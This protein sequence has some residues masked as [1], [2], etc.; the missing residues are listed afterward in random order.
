MTS[1]DPPTTVGV[2]LPV[3]I[4]TRF[5]DSRLRVLIVPDEPW[6]DRHD[7]LPGPAELDLLERYVA[8][9]GDN[10]GAPSARQAWRTFASQVGGGR[11]TWLVRTFRRIASDR[12]IRVERPAAQRD[13]ARLPELPFF[14]PE[15]QVW[16]ARDGAPPALALTLHVDVSR[17]RADFPD[18]DDATDRRWWE[19]WDEAVLTGVA[20]EIDLGGSP[21][22]IEA[23]Y[24][25]GLG[26]DEQE[27][28]R[29]FAAHEAAGR[30]GLIAPGTPTNTVDAAPAADLGDD[31]DTWLTGL[32]APV[33]P[34]SA[35]VSAAL[36]GA[37]G[38]HIPLNNDHRHRDHTTALVAGLWPALWGFAQ[39]NVWGIPHAEQAPA[40]AAEALYPEGPYP[41]LRIGTQP[42]GLLPVTALAAWQA[43]PADP[44]VESAMVPA[45][46]LLR[47][48]WA[49]AAESRGTIE[50]ADTNGLLDHLAQVPTSPGYRHRD[51]RPLEVWLMSLLFLDYRI[52]WRHVVDAWRARTPLAVALD[53]TP[54]R[55][56]AAVGGS[57]PLRLPLVVPAG[58][59]TE[60]IATMLRRL[61]QAA[62]ATPGVLADPE[63]L[64]ADVLGAQPD[65][66]LL[67]LAIRALQ[68]AVG[69]V[70]RAKVA[71]FRWLDP[72][73]RRHTDRVPLEQ[74][75][76]AVAPGDLIAGT[77]A[78]RA[79]ART[80]GGLAAIAD[81]AGDER[82]LDRALSATVDC[83]TYRVDAWVTGPATRRLREL[84]DAP[85]NARGWRLGAYGWVDRPR[86][87]TPGP[88]AA[89]M[90]PA[91]SQSQ[92][93]VAMIL[94]DRAVN[95]AEAGRWHM[96]LSSTTVRTA[97]RLAAA[98]RA[99]THLSEVLGH[100][101]ERVVAEPIAVERLRRDY[102]VRAGHSGRRVCDG[103][104][105]LAAD[106]ATLDLP[107][108]TLTG[109]AQLAAAVDAYGDLLMAEAVQHVVE[110]RAETAGAVL[111]AV[112]GLGRPPDL[113]VIGT[114]RPGRAVL[115]VCV[116]LLPAA[117]PPALPT[118]PGPLSE[119]SPGTLADP[120]FAAFLGVQLGGGDTWTW[121][122]GTGTTV[123]LADLGL[124]P[125]DALAFTGA[126]LERLAADAAGAPL[127]TRVGSARHDRAVRLA[128]LLGQS[129]ATAQALA[130]D[131]APEVAPADDTAVRLRYRRVRTVAQALLARLRSDSPAD[132]QA[133]L[134]AARRW[135]IAP[136]EVTGETPAARAA[137]LLAARLA[138]APGGDLP[139]P[140]T[141]DLVPALVS[142]VS[143]TG[144][145]AVLG[146]LR[147]AEVPGLSPVPELDRDWLTVVAAVR[148]PLAR[149]EAHQLAAGGP[150]SAG[151]AFTSW[152]SRPADPWQTADPPSRLVAGYAAAG[153]DIAA[154]GADDE[155]A[156]A[157]LDRFG[158]TIPGTQ[159][160]PSVV[161]GFAAPT[162]RA[163]QAVLLAVPP[164]PARPLTTADLVAAVAEARLLA[165]ARIARPADLE[166]ARALLPT[167]LL[168]AEGT[169]AVPLVPTPFQES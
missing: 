75:I 105:V 128:L 87:G 161:F 72:I 97:D 27:P 123:T 47:D 100:E 140:V 70:G 25:V 77:P 118:E 12:T 41:T 130:D 39:C 49:A 93:T 19:S 157:L 50:S 99:G 59:T 64:H 131:S 48:E 57:A 151:P 98:V 54:R 146:R 11:A 78:A 58:M 16:L 125:I 155:V 51:A 162:A 15:L 37:D 85:A 7:P 86:T 137:E 90:L 106:P 71:D 68:V 165:H 159:H 65:S 116:A 45:L 127:A 14:P 147:G 8:V 126:H 22:D 26:G 44:P 89:G 129:P 107:A 102:P 92:A 9:A 17:L 150:A 82:R 18:P 80:A 84:H 103:Q 101:V 139:E 109:L 29:L 52:G 81:L 40:W 10:P 144:R 115:T 53:L 122:T 63:R 60:A 32:L 4:E 96:D 36:T 13:T 34:S 5:D 167:A 152:S 38:L 33:P 141:A 148:E 74:W 160:A 111:D 133:A 149:L 46:Q 120:S 135:G 1:I 28:A 143:P 156:V 23:L 110:G 31:P 20:G 168:P 112:A 30:L 113:S 6:F 3:R 66:L 134:A 2:L 114:R 169:L 35:Q 164:D 142:L 79:F 121:T 21:D 132:R 119:L 95:D 166:A 69:D 136:T 91:P 108:D 158:E 61:V 76:G 67:R 56:Y 83:A 94:R 145:L 24:V 163:P 153:L 42:Y 62:R 104:A 117:A 55:R 124:E 154:L 88:S 73:V 43:G 138:A